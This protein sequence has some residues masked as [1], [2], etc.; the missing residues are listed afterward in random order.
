MTVYHGSPTQFNKL[1]AKYMFLDISNAQEGIG[2]YFGELPMAESYGD[3]IVSAEIDPSQFLDSRVIIGDVVDSNDLS[4]LILLLSEPNQETL[5]YLLSDWIDTGE[6]D[7]LD[8]IDEFVS[9]VK[10]DQVRNF[11]ITM[12]QEFG[13]EAFVE[14][15]NTVFP[16]I[17]GTVAP[18]GFYTIIDPDFPINRVK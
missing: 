4:A 3:Y 8:Y 15:W 6:N 10:D 5:Y 11:Q 2:S 13:I 17:K 12:A 1:E 9:F 7:V 16:D 14:A 18:G